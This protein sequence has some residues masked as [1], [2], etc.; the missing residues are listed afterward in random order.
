MDD[1][2]QIPSATGLGHGL[3]EEGK[4]GLSGI[5]PG[6]VVLALDH[7]RVQGQVVPRSAVLMPQMLLFRIEYTHDKDS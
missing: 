1:E 4:H 3:G 2:A 6:G 7:R 5:H